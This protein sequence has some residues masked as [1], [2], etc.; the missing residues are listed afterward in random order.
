MDAF[1]GKS[2]ASTLY[3]IVNIIAFNIFINFEERGF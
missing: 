3:G 2:I 1:G